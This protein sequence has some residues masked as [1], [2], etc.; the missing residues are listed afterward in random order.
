M[1]SARTGLTVN[2]GV[3]AKAAGV[4]EQQLRNWLARELIYLPADADRT[5]LNWRQFGV[6]DILH[7]AAV[8]RL[9][10]YGVAVRLAD[11]VYR[12]FV[13]GQLVKFRKQRPAGS[14]ENFIDSYLQMLDPIDIRISHDEGGQISC[15]GANLLGPHY[16]DLPPGVELIGQDSNPAVVF[17]AEDA[18]TDFAV[19]SMKNLLKVVLQRLDAALKDPERA[20]ANEK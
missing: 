17:A 19:L 2:F 1:P 6:T 3:A 16:F 8:A 20:T 13:A 10:K 12:T 11:W 9:V 4:K 7:I 15:S 18:P 5:D 14:S